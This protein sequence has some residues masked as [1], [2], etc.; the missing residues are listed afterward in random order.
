MSRLTDVPGLSS[1]VGHSD[2]RK[3]NHLKSDGKGSLRSAVSAV[4]GNSALDSLI[5]VDMALEVE[6]DKGM[7]KREGLDITFLGLTS[8][9][10]SKKIRV[11]GLISAASF[12]SGRTNSDRQYYYLNGRP[13]VATKVKC[14]NVIRRLT[15]ANTQ[16]PH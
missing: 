5:D 10:S 11:T 9:F 14:L 8:R 4:W 3:T 16:L 2:R 7:A 15:N 6:I 12:G 1:C 13:F